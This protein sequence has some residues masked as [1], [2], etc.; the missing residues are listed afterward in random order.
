LFISFAIKRRGG[1]VGI[2]LLIIEDESMA[3]AA[4]LLFM[5]T[6]HCC[7]LIHA[8]AWNFWCNSKSLRESK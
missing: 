2:K 4:G 6:L 5:S 8:W 1:L 3:T 7:W